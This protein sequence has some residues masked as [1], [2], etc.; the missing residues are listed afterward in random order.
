MK[1]NLSIEF[2]MIISIVGFMLLSKLITI[3]LKFFVNICIKFFA[4]KL[5]LELDRIKSHLVLKFFPGAV[6]SLNSAQGKKR[7]IVSIVKISCSKLFHQY[8]RN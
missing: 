3:Y 7:S 4:N 2:R 6:M 8:V 5:I 1:I